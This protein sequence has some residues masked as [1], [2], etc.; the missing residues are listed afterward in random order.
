[1][2]V[3]L[4]VLGVIL[5]LAIDVYVI[6]RL[7]GSGNRSSGYASIPVPG[8]ATL[9]LPAG[10]VKFTYQESVHVGGGGEGSPIDFYPP[11]D[12]HLAITPVAGGAPL[13]LRQRGTSAQTV[14]AWFPG[15]P[16]SQTVLG[17]VEVEAGDYLVRAQTS[18]E[19]LVEPVVLVGS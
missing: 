3:A 18:A 19:S 16:R 4:I 7:F 12:F 13:Q 15:G 17:T 11:A 10:K 8:E 1:M 14:A 2:V 6:W 5:F 9:T